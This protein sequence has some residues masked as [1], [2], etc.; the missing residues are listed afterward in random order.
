MIFFTYFCIKFQTMTTF[1]PPPQSADAQQLIVVVA[2]NY[3]LK[4]KNLRPDNPSFKESRVYKDAIAEACYI[5]DDYLLI[6]RK[7]V[8]HMLGMS[9]KVWATYQQEVLFK[10]NHYTWFNKKIED[11]AEEI[12]Q[13]VTP[14]VFV[15]YPKPY[16]NEKEAL[17]S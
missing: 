9:Q 4:K 8:K 10:C 11:Y 17:L 13:I 3:L 6:P 16:A 7:L 15:N 14:Y 12:H 5:L 2:V 1:T